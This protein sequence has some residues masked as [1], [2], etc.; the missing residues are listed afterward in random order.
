MNNKNNFKNKSGN[1]IKV[2]SWLV[3]LTLLTPMFSCTDDFEQIN[4]NPYGIDPSQQDITELYFTPLSNIF[5]NSTAYYQRMQSLNADMYSGYMAIS[6][7]YGNCNSH[8]VMNESWNEYLYRDHA[9]YV[10]KYVL[11]ILNATTEPDMA[12]VA[13]IVRVTSAHRI[14]D[15]YGAIPYTHYGEGGNSVPYD[16][17]ETLYTVFLQELKEC[18]DALTG[19]VDNNPAEAAK[20]RMAK[21]DIINQ[22]NT[23]LWIRFS[24]SLRLRL[25]MRISKVSPALAKTEAEAAVNHKYGVLT[26]TDIDIEVKSE[27]VANCLSVVVQDYNS[28]RMDAF[29]VSLMKGYDD[30]RLPK[31]A[32]GV[33]QQAWY[34]ASWVG[35]S[36]ILGAD[37]Q[38]AD[39]TG[40][41]G[42]FI[43]IRQ[44]IQAQHNGDL[45][46]MYSAP[47][48]KTP[49][50]Y[51]N[52]DDRPAYLPNRQPIMKVAEVLFL[53]AEGALRGWNMGGTAKELYEA[54]IKRSFGQYGISDADYQA[55]INNDTGVCADY[56]DP[57][58]HE[59]DI[60]GTDKETVK[61]D[62][63]LSNERKL[64][65]IINQKWLS[66]YPDGQEAWSDFRRTGY[67]KQFPVANILNADPIPSGARFIKR[68]PFYERDKTT[69]NV[70]EVAKA[71][72][73]L[74]GPDNV[75]T[76][77]WWDV[78]EDDV[79]GG[80]F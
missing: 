29:M 46:D 62:E 55:Y 14:A 2:L 72:A 40:H 24:N 35:R 44:G 13:K 50:S 32:T 1:G 5:R 36:G 59:Y 61:W 45:Y 30:P 6:D 12:S 20:N 71:T 15:C 37:G 26:A 78:N 60:Q 43:G 17:L 51:S 69:L 3:C 53:R 80:N 57:Q 8:Y 77:L 9:R 41:V 63:G 65:K 54:G 18:T 67:P 10:M 11:E 58:H 33:G 49:R 34:A 23:M 76:R 19:F 4:K 7:N 38:P 48:F 16:N 27:R 73:E 25:A 39:G 28:S 42:E 68:L 74:G 56:V 31:Y 21:F 79:D 66:V 52:V 47:N 70:E 64:H 22:G 75:W